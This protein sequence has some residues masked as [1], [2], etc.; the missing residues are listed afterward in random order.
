MRNPVSPATRKAAFIPTVYRSTNDGLSWTDV[1]QAM[2]VHGHLMHLV[3]QGTNLSAG[4]GGH[5]R[6]TDRGTSWTSINFG[7]P[8]AVTALGFSDPC[9]FAGTWSYGVFRSSDYGTSW[10]KIGFGPADV[11]IDCIATIGAKVYPA[12]R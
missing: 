2:S 12:S 10:S 9:L 4:G 5:F 7:S 1:G 3:A 6:S 11:S 8:A